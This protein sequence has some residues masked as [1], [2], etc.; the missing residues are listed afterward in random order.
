VESN[1]EEEDSDEESDSSEGSEES[2]DDSERETEQDIAEELISQ[3]KPVC[4]GYEV[5]DGHSAC[6][7]C[8]FFCTFR[9]NLHPH[10]RCHGFIDFEFCKKKRLKSTLDEDQTRGCRKIFTSDSFESHTCTDDTEDKLG[11]FLIQRG[12][13]NK[14]AGRRVKKKR[15]KKQ[16]YGSPD[17]TPAK[18]YCDGYTKLFHR[19]AAQ[20]GHNMPMD[21]TFVR[22]G[23]LELVY[24]TAG[25]MKA[26]REFCKGSEK[27]YLV[28][29]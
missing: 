23:Q 17:G 21:T 27:Y 16:R 3:G 25:Q 2:D 11:D 22:N 5:T 10:L 14:S 6:N 9:G 8:D 12:K 13:G 26:V 7:F 28:C 29:K 18:F 4:I 15:S 19:L 24:L 20:D 1:E